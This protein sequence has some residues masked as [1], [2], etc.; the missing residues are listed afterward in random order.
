MNTELASLPG[1][2][3]FDLTGRTAVI[4]GGS[5][6]LGAA[7]AAGLPSAGADV[8]IVSRHLAEAQDTADT[9]AQTWSH[10]ALA[11]SV[12]V[13]DPAQVEAMIAAGIRDLGKID[14]LINSAGI[15]VRGPIEDF[16]VET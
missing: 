3:A 16:P 2:R 15:N 11:L 13:T 6:G 4:T 9:I 10:R 7:M 8:M 14:I 1:L 5:K 12:D